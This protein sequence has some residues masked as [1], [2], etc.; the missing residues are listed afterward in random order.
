M[1][2]QPP[3]DPADLLPLS[4]SE[5]RGRL[6]LLIPIVYEELRGLAGLLLSDKAAQLTLQPTAPPGDMAEERQQAGG[7]ALRLP[8]A[9]AR[10]QL[11]RAPQV[12][13]G[14]FIQA[15][16]GVDLPQRPASLFKKRWP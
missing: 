15:E 5:E 2:E 13:L 14:V 8:A 6:D 10:A 1:E 9:L 16:I 11:Q 12:G 4:E 7:L 3:Y